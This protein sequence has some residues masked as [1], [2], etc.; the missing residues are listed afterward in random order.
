[1]TTLDQINAAVAAHFDVSVE[2][3]LGPDRPKTI[4][5]A[6]HAAW[7]AA[8]ELTLRSSV[9]IGRAYGDRDHTTVLAGRRAFAAKLERDERLRDVANA[10][11]DELRS[12]GPRRAEPLTEFDPSRRVA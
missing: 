11:L 2:D 9:E 1:L 4:V 12:K 10:I 7:W 6:R 3:I 5:L 8:Q